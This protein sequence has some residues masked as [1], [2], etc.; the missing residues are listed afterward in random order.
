MYSRHLSR[1]SPSSIDVGAYLF[2]MHSRHA[3]LP[4]LPPIDVGAYLLGMRSRHSKRT[5]LSNILQD[6][7]TFT[8]SP[9]TPSTTP[10]SLLDQ[11]RAKSQTGTNSPRP[12]RPT[13]DVD[14][15]QMYDVIE[16]RNTCALY[17][18]TTP[19]CRVKCASVREQRTARPHHKNGNRRMTETVGWGMTESEFA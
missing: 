16:P 3:N 4:F 6:F 7:F 8:P 15:P 18:T 17:N 5:S 1:L 14:A 19:C 11:Q 13:A 10:T 12:P 2:C 9:P